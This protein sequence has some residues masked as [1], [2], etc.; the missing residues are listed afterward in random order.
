MKSKDET[1]E[2]LNKLITQKRSK[3]TGKYPIKEKRYKELLKN[4]VLNSIDEKWFIYVPSCFNDCLDIAK[5]D[6]SFKTGR[7]FKDDKTGKIKDETEI[8]KEWTQGSRFAFHRGC[9][10]YD[11]P[12][13]YQKWSYAINEIKYC[14]SIHSGENAKPAMDNEERK[15]GKVIFS[16]YSPYPMSTNLEKIGEFTLT[17]D[18]FVKFLVIGNSDIIPK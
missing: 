5:T 7:K 14:I 6:R 18:E 16:I 15:T 11:T 13:A 3:K 17:Q 1:I 12:N 4:P 8:K 2:L 10:L 9:I